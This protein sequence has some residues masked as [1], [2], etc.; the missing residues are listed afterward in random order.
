[1]T[2]VALI[3]AAQV[4][5]SRIHW[6]FPYHLDEVWRVHTAIDQTPREILF[7]R[8]N[9]VGNP[10]GEMLWLNGWIAVF[11]YAPPITRAMSVLV[12]LLTFA[13]FIRLGLDLFDRNATL[14]AVFLLATLPLFAF[15]TRDAGPYPFL[16]WATCALNLAFARWLRTAKA[17]YMVIYVAVGLLGIYT[18]YFIVFVIFSHAV[19]MLVLAKWHRGKFIYTFSAFAAIGLGLLLGQ[20]LQILQVFLTPSLVVKSTLYMGKLDNFR[21]LM[22]L[23]NTVGMYYLL[24][25]VLAV[26]VVAAGFPI[27]APRAGTFIRNGW[28]AHWH[29][30]LTA[31]LFYSV[32]LACLLMG[33]FVRSLNARYL[34]IWFPNLA[35]LCSVILIKLPRPLL[36]GFLV[37]NCIGILGASS[38]NWVVAVPIFRVAEY[39]SEQAAA[40]PTRFILEDETIDSHDTVGVNFQLQR[41]L[42]YTVAN[43]DI[44]LYG[45]RQQSRF[46]YPHHPVQRLFYS[47]APLPRTTQDFLAGADQLFWVTLKDIEADDSPLHNAVNAQFYQV[48]EAQVVEEVVQ[49]AF[50]RYRR[51]I[52][53]TEYRRIGLD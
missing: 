28:R 48:G 6:G 40:P 47:N 45:R 53:V 1:L 46:N 16:V 13:C 3:L 2:F 25:V 34:L 32:F 26:S 27:A 29:L 23:L 12:T 35:L 42:P 39:I 38:N 17:Y 49:G 52:T 9:D 10:P 50:T 15:Y 41:L 20:G 11:G 4:I 30:L 31:I 7:Q 19:A 18:H 21:S 36:V 8:L 37:A 44:L 24:P 51:N 14:L 43:Q 22:T 5:Q 33:T